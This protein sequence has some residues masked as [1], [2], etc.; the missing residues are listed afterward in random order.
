M[1]AL[2][3]GYE[4]KLQKVRKIITVPNDEKSQNL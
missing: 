1:E 3:T 2:R 4:D